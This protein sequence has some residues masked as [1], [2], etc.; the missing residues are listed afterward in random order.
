MP[1]S[2]PQSLS[3]RRGADL[4]RPCA[5]RYAETVIYRIFY[6]VNRNGTGRMTLR[7]L[8]RS[9]LLE[10]LNLLDEE[11]DI[12]KILKYFSYEALLRHLLQ[13]LELDND[14]TS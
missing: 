1:A 5:G 3:G 2:S 9:D 8:N 13:V 10:A 4:R 14:T 6:G 11:E 7:E 12:N